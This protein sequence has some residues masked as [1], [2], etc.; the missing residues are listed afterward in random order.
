MECGGN[1]ACAGGNPIESWEIFS[2]R[3]YVTGG[4][5]GSGIGCKPYLFHC[6][7]D[8]CPNLNFGISCQTSCQNTNFKNET[9]WSG[10]LIYRRSKFYG[11]GNLVTIVN[12]PDLVKLEIFRN[13]P[14]QTVLKY[15]LDAWGQ[16]CD[17]NRDP[18]C[19]YDLE[20]N[21]EQGDRANHAVRLIGWGRQYRNSSL[22]SHPP[23]DYWLAANSWGSEFAVNGTFK[24]Q[25][26]KALIDDLV[27][28]TNPRILHI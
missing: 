21:W 16:K 1:A 11:D 28:V 27:A 18:N 9:G 12:N 20:A 19:I 26:G 23:V 22:I 17:I 15:D 24:V 6:T 4:P 5:A 7:A 8:D 10:D 3:G 13:G 2:R 25:I 14:V